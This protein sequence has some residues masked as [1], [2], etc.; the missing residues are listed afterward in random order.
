MFI[1]TSQYNSAHFNALL[2]IDESDLRMREA[3]ALDE[4]LSLAGPLFLKHD[5]WKHWGICLL[6]K[7]WELE[8]DEIPVQM[9]E[10][11]T[12]LRKYVLQPRRGSDTTFATPSILCAAED[13]DRFDVLEYSTTKR[14]AKSNEIVSQK[15]EFLEELYTLLTRTGLGRTFGVISTIED[16]RAGH[17]FVELTQEG[18][19]SLLSEMPIAEIDTARLIETSWRFLPTDA[20]TACTRTCMATCGR[21]ADGSHYNAGHISG[22][23]RT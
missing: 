14:A 18:R 16:A 3:G 7:H 6:H 15:R 17:K 20:N 1:N 10:Q 5:A 12:H 22:H 2:D 8:E 19:I 21:N 11:A 23:T 4:V 13:N 9:E